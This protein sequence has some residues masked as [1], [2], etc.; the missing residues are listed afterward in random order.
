MILR[1]LLSIL[2]VLSYFLLP[3]YGF[4]SFE[5][6]EPRDGLINHILY[7]LSHANIFHLAANIVFLW[8]VRC[9]LHLAVTFTI[10]IICSFFPCYTTEPTMGCSGVLFAMVG[11]T[12]GRAAM[13]K[14]MFWR[15]KWIFLIM[16]LAPHVNFLIHIY[17]LLAGFLF[18]LITKRYASRD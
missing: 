9:K 4:T 8:M 16:I 5:P 14:S 13:F 12:W 7:P 15:N 10:A 1:I 2:L 18:G 11:I 6:S 17:C 3:K